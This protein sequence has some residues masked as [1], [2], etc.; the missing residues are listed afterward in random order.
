MRRVRSRVDAALLQVHECSSVMAWMNSSEGALRKRRN[1]AGCAKRVACGRIGHAAARRNNHASEICDGFAWL[2]AGF[3]GDGAGA[4][5]S[6][7]T[8]PLTMVVP[9]R[10]RRRHRCAR[11]GSS[12]GASPRSWGPQVI[13]ENVGGA[14]G[15][16]GSARVAK[17]APDGYQFVLGSRADAINQTLYKTPLYNLTH[18]SRAGRT[19]RRSA[20][21]AGRPQ[22]SAGRKSAGVHRV[23]QED[24]GGDAIRLRRRRLHRPVSTAPCSIA[25]IGVSIAQRALSRRRP[26]DAGSDCR[27]HRLFLHA[28]RDR[29]VASR[30]Q[31]WS[32]RSR[33]CR[34]SARP[35]CRRS[36]PRRSRA[37]R[38]SMRR[39]GSG[40]FFLRP[41][42]HPRRRSSRSSTDANRE[43]MDTPS[44]QERLKEAA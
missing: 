26:G 11:V 6:W 1:V 13:I 36:Q 4:A 25:A 40:F 7:P 34:A 22:G 27:P 19:D 38:I 33:T 35:C 44:V 20:H 31:A 5:E 8:R 24:A 41:P 18:R 16:V 17:A 9:V 30:G 37:S 2:A 42:A 3:G 14:G 15:M 39:P 32:S 10:G 28:E 43:A 21:R 12:A 29:G 23:C